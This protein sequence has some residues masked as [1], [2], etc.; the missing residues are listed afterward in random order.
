[1][2]HELEPT[3]AGATQGGGALALQKRQA[4]AVP[5]GFAER[6]AHWPQERM[7]FPH[8]NAEGAAGEAFIGSDGKLGSGG[9]TCPRCR[10]AGT[11]APAPFEAL[12]LLSTQRSL[13]SARGGDVWTVHVTMGPR[14]GRS[15]SGGRISLSA[16]PNCMIADRFWLLTPMHPHNIF[17]ALH[18]FSRSWRRCEQSDRLTLI[19]SEGRRAACKTGEYSVIRLDGNLAN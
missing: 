3:A 9:F 11:P 10:C 1:M 2:L 14:W 8:R 15:C 7:G 13:N 6:C 5:G 19:L 16:C 4:V 17:S 12:V 18:T